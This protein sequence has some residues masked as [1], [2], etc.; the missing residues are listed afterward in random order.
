V[1]V[2]AAGRLRRA[3]DL[4]PPHG[5][6]AGAALL[7]VGLEAA[8]IHSGSTV[9]LVVSAAVALAALTVL[10]RSQDELRLWP[11][12]A[13]AVALHLGWIWD[14]TTLGAVG[15]QDPNVAYSTQGRELVHGNFPGSEYPVGAVLLFGLESLLGGGP[16]ETANRFLM[17]PFQLLCVLCVWGVRTRQSR[18]LAAV[19]A[20]WPM[21]TYYLEYRFD[22]V[23]AALIVLG[24]VLAYRGRWA[25]SGTALA[26]GATVKWTPGL[27]F[28]ALAVWLVAGRRWVDLRRHAG[29]FVGVAALLNLPFLLFARDDF[30]VPYR[31][32]G[33]R[34]ITNESLWYLPLRLV[35]LTHA[36]PREWAP[37]G[38]PHWADVAAVVLQVGLLLGLLVLVTG[39]RDRIRPAV[40][41]AA[42]APVVFLVTNRI[43]SPQFLLVLV[44]ALAF[45]GALVAVSRSEQ[46]LLGLLVMAASFL[47]AFVYPYDAPYGIVSW[48]FLAPAVFAPA[49]VATGLVVR[50]GVRGPVEAEET[51]PRLFPDAVAEWRRARAVLRESRPAA[52]A[53]WVG[54]LAS[55]Q[56]AALGAVFLAPAVFAAA[57]L[58]YRFWDSLAFG[59]WSRVIAVTGR[60]RTPQV[61]DINLHRPLFY[62]AQGLTWRAFGYHEWMGRLLSVAF[63]VALVVGVWLLA[64]RL[65]RTGDERVLLRGFATGAVLASSVVATYVAAGMADLPVAAAATATAVALWSSQLG[66]ARAPLVALAAAATLLGKPTGLLA[67]VGLA[68]AALVLRDRGRRLDGLAGLAAGTAL[69]LVYDTVEAHRIGDS[70]YGFLR[71]GNADYWT[72]R[73]RAARWD[74]TVRAEWL[75]AGL[76][77][78]LL[79]GLLHAVARVAGARTRTALAIAGPLAIA[80]SVV[81]PIVADGGVPYPFDR[82]GPGLLAYLLVAG[83]ILAAPLAAPSD[84]F[85]RRL[86]LALLLWVAPGAVAWLAYRADEVRFLS[87]AWPGFVLL[88]AAGLAVVA[89]GLAR[90]APAAPLVPVLGV[91]LL[92]LANVP[93]ID[94]LGRGGWHGLLDLGRSGWTSRAATENYAYGPFSYELDLARENVGPRDQIVSN[95]ARLTYFFPGRVLVTYPSSC[96][97]LG[98]ASYFA[99]LTGGESLDFAR[100][101][102]SPTNPLAW[103]QCRR[104]RVTLVGAQEGIY[105]S[106]V[107]GRRP[108]RAPTL[109]DCHLSSTPGQ[110]DDAVFAADVDYATARD[111]VERAGKVGFQHIHI[112]QTACSSFRVVITGLP[113]TAAGQADF[114]HEAESTGFH[115]MFVPAVRYP[116]VPADVPAVS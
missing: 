68:A 98:D 81:G 96:S 49:L 101:A 22:L 21:D 24:L 106:F 5:V 93:S 18:W 65:A 42:L 1:P 29:A 45:A 16:A 108:A 13:V 14:H 62:V 99:L 9:W 55:W 47:N 113:T 87:P 112:E 80:W 114:R 3:V 35:G 46:L 115:V 59:Q 64:G 8:R 6:L 76:R 85:D 79:F 88:A 15:D 32:Q 75:G 33:D 73:G 4:L 26:L 28:A 12:V 77:L 11:L 54:R 36:D 100:L 20:L 58:P 83:S 61:I 109:S 72:A 19:I 39:V 82:F 70:L 91:A 10:W 86:Y 41:L 40:A 94:G 90:L 53:P 105:A 74:A 51:D 110:L 50:R 102:N 103:L 37:A 30:L 104:P 60:F 66:R 78:V 27:S 116:E 69:A 23:P 56:V 43:F 89:L 57:V 67:L 34:T 52:L 97:S 25:W 38:A 107:V 31:T 111:V 92:A 84:P 2:T 95:D 71:A 63:G 48:R 17:V 44:A 7:E